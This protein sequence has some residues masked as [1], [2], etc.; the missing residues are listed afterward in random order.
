MLILVAATFRL[1]I[2]KA[3]TKVCGY[4]PEGWGASPPQADRPYKNNDLAS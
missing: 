1:R 3:Q 2:I 4:L